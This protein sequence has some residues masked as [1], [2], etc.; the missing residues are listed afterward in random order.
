MERLLNALADGQP[1][2]VQTLLRGQAVP[3]DLGACVQ[4][5]IDDGRAVLSG[6]TLRLVADD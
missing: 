2:D 3:E 5:L 4:Q 6:Q 1:H